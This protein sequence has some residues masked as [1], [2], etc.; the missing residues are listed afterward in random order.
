M[1]ETTIARCVS[2]LCEAYPGA[3]T[4]REATSTL[5]RLPRTLLP[6]GCEPKSTEALVVFD[7]AKDKP[8]ILLRTKPKTP[9]GVEPRNVSAE[10][11]G[12]EAWFTFSF[13]LAWDQERHTAAQF[14][15]GA[16]RRFAKNE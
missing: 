16:L 3:V 11:V 7:P 4:A 12:G 6:K 9:K 1:M 15:E 14:V 8:R 5:V 2:E 13:D 10:A